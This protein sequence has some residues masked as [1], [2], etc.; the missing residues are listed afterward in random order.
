MDHL[1][2]CCLLSHHKSLLN[3]TAQPSDDYPSAN[4]STT[5]NNTNSYLNPVFPGKRYT[6]YLSGTSTQIRPILL[7]GSLGP[8]FA[9]GF[10]C[11]GNCTSFL[12]AVFIVVTE[13]ESGIF[14]IDKTPPQVIWSANRDSLVSI[15]AIL[16]FTATR[17]LVLEDV[18]GSSVWNTN[19]AGKSVVDCLLP[20]QRLFQGQQL[21]PSV[22]STDWTAQKGL[23]SLQLADQILFASAGSNTPQVYYQN[24]IMY[25]S[26]ERV[27]VRFLNGS[28]SFFDSS[29]EPEVTIISIP[30]ASSAQ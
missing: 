4:L 18:D 24:Q 3:T 6:Y 27:Y 25:T 8:T 10:Y 13:R 29:A 7:R 16:N 5:W 28:L 23:F 21:I 11:N 19:T 15:G 14:Y 20:G 22:S 17:E 1:L 9:C 30:F 12:F 2:L 26:E